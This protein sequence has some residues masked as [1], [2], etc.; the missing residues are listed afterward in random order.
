MTATS[1]A[2]SSALV[3]ADFAKVLTRSTTCLG[4]R[5]HSRANRC[6]CHPSSCSPRLRD[7]PTTCITALP[8]M[9]DFAR[10]ATACEGAFWPPGTFIAAYN[11]NRAEAAEQ[12]IE[13]DL[14]ASAVQ[15]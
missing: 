13:T 9:A 3:S 5:P 4:L 15:R 1:A 12:L 14:V 8:R 11:N 6:Q 10:W 7:L 2:A